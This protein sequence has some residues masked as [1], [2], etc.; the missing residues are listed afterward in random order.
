M[1]HNI[2]LDWKTHSRAIAVHHFVIMGGK[3]QKFVSDALT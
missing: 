1:Y 3:I 2:L